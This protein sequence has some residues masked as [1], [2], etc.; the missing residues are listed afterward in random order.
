MSVEQKALNE[1][2]DADA[3]KVTPVS[4]AQFSFEQLALFRI[5]KV[6]R[7]HREL[8]EIL[9]VEDQPFSSKLLKSMLDQE[10]VTHVAA[11]A[12]QAWMLYATH[13]P[14]ICLLDIELPDM[15]GHNLAKIIRSIDPEAHIIMVTA[16]NFLEDVTRAKENGAKGF[17]IKPYSKQK[18]LDAVHKFKRER[19]PKR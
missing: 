13:A 18:I 6:A 7:Q 19:K 11:S 15:S 17:I 2:Q 10:Y 1:A 3:S 16:N 5:S 8:P 9:I 14:E 12:G 4:T